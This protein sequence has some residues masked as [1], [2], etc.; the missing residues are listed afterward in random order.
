MGLLIF[1]CLSVIVFIGA[2]AE[3]ALESSETD[4]L[5]SRT[6]V[7]E[8]RLNQC[9]SESPIEKVYSLEYP[10]DWCSTNLWLVSVQIQS[11]FDY[12]TF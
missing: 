11:K 4:A 12:Q 1:L 8:D 9:D 5:Q 7:V 3:D 2:A 6:V 10:F